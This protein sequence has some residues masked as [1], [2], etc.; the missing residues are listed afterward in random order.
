MTTQIKE[1]EYELIDGGEQFGAY[2]VLQSGPLTPSCLATQIGTSERY[3][4]L[5]LEVQA[6]AGLLV[7]QRKTDL[8]CL[9]TSWSPAH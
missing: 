7:H 3:A 4:R 1:Q 5:W 2:E 8:F 9:W 6:A